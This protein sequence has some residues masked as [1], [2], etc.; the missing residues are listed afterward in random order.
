MTDSLVTLGINNGVAE[1]R[2]NRAAKR[3]ALTRSLLEEAVR[4]VEQVAGNKMARLL[5]ISADGPVFCAGM[6]LTEMQ[7]RATSTHAKAEWGAD[8]RLYRDLVAAIFSLD[9][10]TLCLLHGPVVAGGVGIVAACD[11]VL[12]STAATVSLPE[13]KR[14]ITAAIVTPLLIHRI[15]AGAA[16]ALLL[17][18]HTMTSDE[19]Q[20]VGFCHLLCVPTELDSKR[21]ELSNSILTGS[22]GALAMTK[23]HIRA[24]AAAS[25]IEQLDASMKVSAEARETDDARE[26]LAAFLEKREP[27]WIKRF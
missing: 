23:R 12:A 4:A 9:I 11:L 21:Q 20:R 8:A 2:L 25:I 16:T 3:N 24:C 26:G 10:P 14:G 15:G 1:L 6:D 22:P 5:V 18:G 17:S 27:N 7:E 13:P 19:M